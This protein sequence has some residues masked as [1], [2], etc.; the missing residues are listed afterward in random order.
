MKAKFFPK[1]QYPVSICNHRYDADITITEQTD[2]IQPHVRWAV[3]YYGYKNNIRVGAYIGKHYID[4]V[5]DVSD[6]EIIGN[7]R[8]DIYL[9][10]I[11]VA[12]TYE[13]AMAIITP[14]FLDLTGRMHSAVSFANGNQTWAAF[15][16]N[17]FL[18]GRN[19]EPSPNTEGE[20]N[21]GKVGELFLGNPHLD[22]TRFDYANRESTTRW[23]D[24]DMS[25]QDVTNVIHDV[26]NTG[27]WYRN[28]THWH[29]L[30]SELYLQNE[31]YQTLNNAVS[32]VGK[33]AH[34]CS[35]G[36][37]LEYL[38]FRQKIKK[39]AC[40]KSINGNVRIALEVDDL[41]LQDRLN[42]PVSVKIDLSDSHLSGKRIKCIGC[43]IVSL[44]NDIYIINVPF[45]VDKDNNKIIVVDITE[46]VQEYRNNN[47]PTANRVVDGN[48]V[49][50][51]TSQKTRL[52]VFRKLVSDPDEKYIRYSR[53]M[54]LNTIH[55]IYGL[56]FATYRYAV[57]FAN[58]FQVMGSLDI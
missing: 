4:D 32:S 45:R 10:V 20:S 35:A 25:W 1:S 14:W 7:L 48:K 30:S 52:V 27:G 3:E 28:F 51:T 26:I 43:E 56:D 23:H 19:S 47:I 13:E 38:V 34:F 8:T 55:T 31:F 33:K 18:G 53:M 54:D 12:P 5:H 37:A 42:T 40:Y 16:I 41:F 6:L 21:Y 22:Y 58:K 36:E 9:N 24:N 29:G 15:T 11:P 17:D 50:I 49:T 39:K 44:G 57:G 46:G 2:T